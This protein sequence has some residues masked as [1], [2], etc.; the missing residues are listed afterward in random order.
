MNVLLNVYICALRK[1][2][3]PFL[4]QGTV[5]CT[6]LA[7]KQILRRRQLR[8]INPQESTLTLEVEE[9]FMQSLSAFSLFFG[10]KKQVLKTLSNCT[11]I[12][13]LL[14]Y[15]PSYSS[16]LRKR[17]TLRLLLICLEA[18]GEVFSCFPARTVRGQWETIVSSKAIPVDLN[19][20]FISKV[21]HSFGNRGCLHCAILKA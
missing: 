1:K 13:L 9:N 7:Q 20:K 16:Q 3:I 6:H 17:Y 5:K 14:S 11:F 12:P 18:L 4:P 2:G 21:N 10:D 19:V 15:S 8:K